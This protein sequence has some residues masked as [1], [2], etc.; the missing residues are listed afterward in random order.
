MPSLEFASD[1]T[2]IT[3]LSTV[4]PALTPVYYETGAYAN[5]A[6]RIDY[7]I[8]PEVTIGVGAKNLFDQNV[9]LTDG[10]PEPGRSFF[11]SIRARY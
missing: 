11:A 10:F 5:A 7:A 4:P 9:V 8:L 1:R 2:T 3:T 6:I